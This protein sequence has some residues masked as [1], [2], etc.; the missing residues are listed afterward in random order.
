MLGLL[1][2]KFLLVYRSFLGYLALSLIVSIF[3]YMQNNQTGGIMAIL[4]TTVF[5]SI[6]PIELMKKETKSHFNIFVLT[7]PIKRQTI[8]MS[9]FTFYF[10]IIMLGIGCATLFYHL[11]V[12]IDSQYEIVMI[13]TI[14]SSAFLY[15]LATGAGIYFFTTILGNEQSEAIVIGSAILG[16]GS[17]FLVNK[18]IGWLSEHTTMIDFSQSTPTILINCF[19]GLLLFGVSYVISSH[20]FTKKDF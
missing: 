6:I 17:Y 16:G 10:G 3:F 19:V 11:M 15:A 20:L 1:A 12:S 2:T 13:S 14:I 8:M 7:L 9:H 4:I 18:G 5:V